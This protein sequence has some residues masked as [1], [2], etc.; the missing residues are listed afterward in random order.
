MSRAVLRVDHLTKRFGGVTALA[1]FSCAVHPG[2]I[3]GL[4][5]PNGAGKSTFFDVV[6]GFLS[7]DEGNVQCQG[8]DITGV[9][10]HRVAQLGIARTFQD[11]RLIRRTTVLWNVLLAFQQQLGEQLR[12]VFFRPRQTRQAEREIH[13][14]AFAL[15]ESTGLEAHAGDPAG[16]LSYGQQKLLSIVCCVASDAAILLLDEP[17]AGIA[18]DRVPQIAAIVES[19]ATQGKSVV[20]IEHDIDLLA[21]LCQRLIFLDAGRKVAEGTPDEVRRDVAALTAYLT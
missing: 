5:G 17:A 2:E 6:T 3:V 21:K 15:L 13:R 9:A 12:N 10:P 8:H 19:L 7:P 11:L 20:V 4:M 18:L 14:R 16:A 1:E